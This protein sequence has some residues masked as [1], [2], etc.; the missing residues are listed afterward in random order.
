MRVVH[1]IRLTGGLCGRGRRGARQCGRHGRRGSGRRIHRRGGRWFCERRGGGQGCE[2]QGAEERQR[3][4][5]NFGHLA[6]AIFYHR[7]AGASKRASVSNDRTA[8]FQNRTHPFA[9]IAVK[10][11][12]AAQALEIFVSRGRDRR[13]LAKHTDSFAERGD[14]G[15]KNALVSPIYESGEEFCL[16]ASGKRMG[17]A[18]GRLPAPWGERGLLGS[19]CLADAETYRDAVDGG[20]QLGIGSKAALATLISRAAVS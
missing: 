1:G 3:Q 15:G 12:V 14:R 18:V 17:Q 13:R 10:V 16:R 2:N 8:L 20:S 9:I 4:E 11:N 19:A 7:T 5:S 6:K